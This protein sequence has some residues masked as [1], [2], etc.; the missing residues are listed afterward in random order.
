MPIPPASPPAICRIC[1]DEEVTSVAL[2]NNAWCAVPSSCQVKVPP[3][4]PPPPSF[5][6]PLPPEPQ[7]VAPAASTAAASARHAATATIECELFLTSAACRSTPAHASAN[8]L[9]IA[10]LLSLEA[11][12][13][14]SRHDD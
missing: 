4:A 5:A 9:R 6:T 1:N 11:A 3:D 8:A 12:M 10:A 7:P 13:I 14:D 2:A